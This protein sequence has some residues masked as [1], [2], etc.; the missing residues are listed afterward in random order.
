MLRS[1]L[2]M[3]AGLLMILWPSQMIH[4]MVMAIGALFILAGIYTLVLYVRSSETRRTVHI[5]AA[6][7]SLLLGA[8]LM[9]VPSFFINILMYIWGILL[10][11]SGT[12]QI[13]ALIAARKYTTVHIAYYI[14]P[15]IIIAAGIVIMLHPGTVI[16][17]TFIILGALSL[18]YGINELIGWYIFRPQKAPIVLAN[19]VEDADIIE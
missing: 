4:Y 3:L 9:I 6:I 11:L 17:K 15:A 1:I 12:Q 5:V 7:A 14:L 10:A 2:A 18:L 8:W 13:V 16:S 19:E